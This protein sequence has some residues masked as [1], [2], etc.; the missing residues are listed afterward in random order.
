MTL[1]LA[2][3]CSKPSAEMPPSEPAP[4]VASESKRLVACE[5]VSAAEMST[6]V[7][8]EMKA[9]PEEENSTKCTYQPTSGSSM[10]IVQLAVDIGGGEAAMVAMKMMR[11][12]ENGELND[13]LRGVGDQAFVVGPEAMIRRGEDLVRIMVFGAEDSVAA[14]KRIFETASSRLP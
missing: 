14:T 3:G 6:I 9:T 1:V 10:P 13:P 12:M 8:V 5:L 11:R 4:A 7:T 2:A